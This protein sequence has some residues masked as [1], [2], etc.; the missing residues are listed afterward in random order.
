MSK[1]PHAEIFR[2]YLDHICRQPGPSRAIAWPDWLRLSVG[3]TLAVGATLGPVACGGESSM[4]ESTTGA[5][6]GTCLLEDCSAECSDGLDNDQ[7]GATDCDDSSCQNDASCESD[8]GAP[9]AGGDPGLGGVAGLGGSAYGI[10]Y[11]MSCT[12]GVDDNLNGLVDC[13]DPTCSSDVACT[14]T[15]GAPGA[16]GD[17]GLGGLGGTGGTPYSIP[18]EMS[19]DNGFDDDLDSMVDCSDPDC[20]TNAACSGSGGAGGYGGTGGDPPIGGTAGNGGTGGDP[21]TGGIIG[22]GGAAYG[23]PFEDCTDGIDNNYDGLADCDDPYCQVSTACQGTGGVAGAGGEPGVGGEP[24]IGGMG[25]TLYGVP[26]ELY[27]DNG[28]SDDMD[29]LVDCDD[30]DCFDD[31]ACAE[32]GGAGGE[33]GSTAITCQEA[34]GTCTTVPLVASPCAQCDPTT[35]LLRIPAPPSDSA[36]G[37]TANDDGVTPLCCLPVLEAGDCVNAGGGCYPPASSGE[38]C[39]VGWEAVYTACPGGDTCCVPGPDCDDS[40]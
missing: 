12:D 22:Y 14:G 1:R 6:E 7:D 25:G 37:C 32:V 36:L 20:A 18:Y 31:P 17:P 3:G 34:A 13:A 2:A 24:G 28:Y 23:V 39:P 4:G 21:G 16:G 35:A 8:G 33:G 26:Y 9:G 15:G 38:T 5:G 40:G 10:P 27:C 29:G 11:E 30:P 19:C